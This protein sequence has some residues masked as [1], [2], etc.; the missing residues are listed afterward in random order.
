[1]KT[2]E[3]NLCA[4]AAQAWALTGPPYVLMVSTEDR[5]LLDRF[6]WTAARSGRSVYADSPTAAKTTGRRILHRIIMPSEVEVDHRDRNGLNCMR[7]NLRAATKRQNQQNRAARRGRASVYKG[8]KLDRRPLSKRWKAAIT[9]DG[10]TIWL[11]RHE[12]EEAAAR[13][14]D[15]AARKHFGEFARLNFAVAA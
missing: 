2:H 4:C 15:A 6:W 3:V 5:H 7:D 12:T 13:A 8:V 11:G 9:V 10:K 14:Y 1:M